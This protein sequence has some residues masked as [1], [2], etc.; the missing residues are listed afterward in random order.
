VPFGSP[1]AQEAK[2]NGG[3]V[4][5]VD[6]PCQNCSPASGPA[7]HFQTSSTAASLAAIQT[8]VALL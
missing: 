8:L 4:V 1:D 7:I 6:F 3:V 2:L 5:P